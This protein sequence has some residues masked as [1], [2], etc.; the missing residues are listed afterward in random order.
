MAFLNK[1]LRINLVDERIDPDRVEDPDD[2]DLDNLDAGVEKV[3]RTDD[4]AGA[5]EDVYKR[6]GHYVAGGKA[7]VRM[8]GMEVKVDATHRG[9]SGPAFCAT[10]RAV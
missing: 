7:A 2:V 6:Q 10:K 9:S 1:G 3:T 8:G 4:G 5:A